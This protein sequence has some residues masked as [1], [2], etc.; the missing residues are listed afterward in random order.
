MAE[1]AK[2]ESTPAPKTGKKKLL[3]LIAAVGVVLGG[4][5]LGVYKFAF[6]KSAEP[7]QTSKDPKAVPDAPKPKIVLLKPIIV[8]LRDTRGTRYLKVTIGMEVSSDQVVDGLNEI[9]VPLSDF[10]IDRLSSLRIEDL[11]NTAGR[12]K[13]KRELLIGTNDLLS[14]TGAGA[15]SRL[16]FSEFV[17]Q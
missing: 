16:Y 13:L 5:G 10:L 11:D 3:I 9:M 1:E 15:V 7:E 4:G 2:P 17:I 12:N 8:N 6:A 14:E